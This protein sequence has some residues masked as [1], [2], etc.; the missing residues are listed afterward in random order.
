MPDAGWI[1]TAALA[2]GGTGHDQLQIVNAQIT[3]ATIT[4]AK[5]AAGAG[6]AGY[7]GATGSN[8]GEA[9]YG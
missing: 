3:D 4:A 1:I 7:Y 6:A 2:P 8:Y 5:L 9:T